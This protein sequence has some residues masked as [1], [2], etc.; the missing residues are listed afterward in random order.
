MRT[1]YIIDS[2]YPKDHYVDRADG[3]IAQQILKALGIRADLRMALD[4][5]YFKKAVTRATAAGC[6]VLHISC[7][8]DKDGVGLCNDDPDNEEA[9]Q[10]YEW[11]EFVGL[12]QGKYEPPEALVMSACCGAASGLG[13]AFAKAKKRPSIIIGSRDKR[14]AAD[15][16]AA[17]SLLYRAFKRSGIHQEVAQEVL[18]AICAVVDKNFRYL[19]WS[20]EKQRYLQYPSAGKLYEVREKKKKAK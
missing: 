14:F 17:W 16:V 8:G 13:H 9:P 2:N 12:F 11:E 19:R 1:V 3:P 18:E 15:Y 10:G 5:E 4:R 7:H 6:D 20:D